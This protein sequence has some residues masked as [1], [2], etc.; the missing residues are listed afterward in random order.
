MARP[1]KALEGMVEIEI[2]ADGVFIAED[3]R[4][5]KAARAMVPADIAKLLIENGHG[6]PV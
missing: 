3:E 1:K 4:R 5:D 2:T 6:K